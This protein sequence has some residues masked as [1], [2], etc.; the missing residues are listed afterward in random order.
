MVLTRLQAKQAFNHILDVVI[1]QGNGTPLKSS[2]LD[3]GIEDIFFLV[4]VDSGTIEGLTY[5]DPKD[6]TKHLAVSKGDKAK[7]RV[8]KDFIT[9]RYNSG[10]PIA[11]DWTS[12]TQEEYDSFRITAPY[13]STPPGVIHRT[14]AAH[15][16]T[17]PTATTTCGIKH[18]PGLS[19]TCK[20]EKA[21]ASWIEPISFQERAQDISDVVDDKCMP[22]TP[23]AKQ[24][25]LMDDACEPMVNVGHVVGTSKHCQTHTF[26]TQEVLLCIFTG[27]DSPELFGGEE[28][29]DTPCAEL[30]GGEDNPMI[31]PHHAPKDEETNIVI[32]PFHVPKDGEAKLDACP[33][34]MPSEGQGQANLPPTHDLLPVVFDPGGLHNCVTTILACNQLVNC[35]FHA[36][37]CDWSKHFYGELVMGRFVA[38]ILLLLNETPI[39]WYFKK[40]HFRCRCPYRQMGSDR[41]RKSSFLGNLIPRPPKYFVFWFV[42]VTSAVVTSANCSMPLNVQKLT[43]RLVNGSTSHS[44]SLNVQKLSQRLANR[45]TPQL[46]IQKLFQRQVHVWK[47][48][49]CNFS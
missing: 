49:Q 15:S 18:D 28:V 46:N 40:Q 44:T 34:F 4:T 9:H 45:S 10:S 36:S 26:D 27:E 48:V 12:I 2:L 24:Q 11:D 23:N 3:D 42:F 32:K 35:L 33:P 25:T 37:V 31:K 7:I 41:K 19:P 6:S 8:F 39:D 1:G 14:S 13:I 5:V 29:D 30:F 20:V 17:G 43:Q 21:H 38:S 22:S 47:L 16:S